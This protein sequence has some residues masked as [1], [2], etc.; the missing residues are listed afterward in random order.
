MGED[1]KAN[2]LLKKLGELN[3]KYGDRLMDIP[4]EELE[5]L[6]PAMK[7]E[8][9]NAK[10][11]LQGTE[12][13]NSNKMT[14]RAFSTNIDITDFNLKHIDTIIK[15]KK[16]NLENEK[17]END[18]IH[19]NTRIAQVIQD[20]KYLKTYSEEN[21]KV[22]FKNTQSEKERKAE[23]TFINRY[24]DSKNAK[25]TLQEINKTIDKDP[26]VKMLDDLKYASLKNVPINK[27]KELKDAIEHKF[28]E[29][30]KFENKTGSLKTAENRFNDVVS[31]NIDKIIHARSNDSEIP[32]DININQM[33]EV[34][35]NLVKQ[36]LQ[37]NNQNRETGI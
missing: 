17:E 30:S 31:K 36:Q 5:K 34:S 33:L 27:L 10:K 24:K 11:L 16:N 9:V 35:K 32:Y 28:E 20:I 21:L 29:M 6:K 1:K 8:L 12:K 13:N 3:N 18:E 22:G 26:L 2:D 15:D 25:T 23:N 4:L 19:D 7:A 14:I 37:S